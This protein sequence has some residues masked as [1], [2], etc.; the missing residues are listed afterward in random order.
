MG[1]VAPTCQA[2]DPQTLT[3]SVNEIVGSRVRLNLKPLRRTYAPEQT[4]LIARLGGPG[5]PIIGQ[6]EI[7]EFV[8]ESN[9]KQRIVV[10]YETG[11]GNAYLRQTPLIRDLDLTFEMFAA[12][13]TFE[14]GKSELFTSTNFFLP[15]TPHQNGDEISGIFN[16]QIWVPERES[17]YCFRVRIYQNG[18]IIGH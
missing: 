2:G 15:E 14:N 7:E 5:G 12:R 8:T 6:K 3:V 4:V 1:Q 18:T 17:M 16:F 10:A 9:A 13:S 11:K